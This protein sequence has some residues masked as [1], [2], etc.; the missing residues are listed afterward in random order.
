[1]IK[2]DGWFRRR[3][4]R[5]PNLTFGVNRYYFRRLKICQWS[6]KAVWNDSFSFHFVGLTITNIIDLSIW[7]LRFKQLYMYHVH[8]DPIFTNRFHCKR[9]FALWKFRPGE[10]SRVRVIA[11]AQFRGCKFSLRRNFGKTKVTFASVDTKFQQDDS[12]ISLD[13]T[14]I[15]ELF[16][17]ILSNF[18]E[19]KERKTPSFV[20]IS[21][22]QYCGLRI[23]SHQVG[24][25]FS[26][27]CF[28][29]VLV[30]V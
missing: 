24:V 11:M 9:N 15:R 23:Y 29:Y 14:K 21:F 25:A 4:L 26:V 6:D 20:C 1:M 12:E 28:V 5:V 2:F 3:T 17:E 13:S 19:N 22:A 10:I 16:D 8:N 7:R 27:L 30:A 18:R